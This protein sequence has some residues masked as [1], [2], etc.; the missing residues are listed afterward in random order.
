MGVRRMGGG[1]LGVVV[2]VP[3][4]GV[5]GAS[6]RVAREVGLAR[7]QVGL[8]IGNVGLTGGQQLGLA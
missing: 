3:G 1:G 5:I 4:R 8:A 6:G 2:V 7:G